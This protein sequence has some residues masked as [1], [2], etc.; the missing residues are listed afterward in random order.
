M[1]VDG[2]VEGLIGGGG[3]TGEYDNFEYGVLTIANFDLGRFG[4]LKAI[5]ELFAMPAADPD[6]LP[7]ELGDVLAKVNPGQTIRIYASS[8]RADPDEPLLPDIG[9]ETG[10]IEVAKAYYQGGATVI[11]NVFSMESLNPAGGVPDRDAFTR[12]RADFTYTIGSEAALGPFSSVD[13]ITVR[14]TFNG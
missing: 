9:T 2:Q 5:T 13:E 7:M 1:D 3:S 12:L 4:G 6:Y 14:F 8:S 11:E 10:G